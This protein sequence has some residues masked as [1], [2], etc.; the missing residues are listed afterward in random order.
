MPKR[1]PAKAEQQIIIEAAPWQD[2]PA[3]AALRRPARALAV[4]RAAVA[5]RQALADAAQL[6]SPPEQ[7]TVSSDT[8]KP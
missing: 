1:R 2:E 6:G 5:K 3:P 7:G 4:L 8:D